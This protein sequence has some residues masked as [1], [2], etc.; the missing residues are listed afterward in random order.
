[1]RQG[2]EQ[3]MPLLTI[4]IS[5][6]TAPIEVRERVALSSSEHLNK[7][8]SLRTLE[9]VDEALMLATC[10]RLEIYCYGPGPDLEAVL[11]WVHES[12]GLESDRLDEYFYWHQDTEAIRHLMRVAGGMDSLVLGESQ[13]LGQL[14]LAWDTARS[15]ETAG[16]IIDRLCQHA[17]TAAKSIRHHGAVGDEP[18]SVAYTAIVLA[19]RLFSDLSARRVLLVGAGEMIELC[20]RHLNQHGVKHLAIAN[21]DAERAQR[22]A[23]ELGAKAIALSELSEALPRADILITSTAS[24]RPI[25]KLDVVRE[26][27]I[28]RRR[29]PM[30]I[31][32]IAVP[33]D[34]EP[35]VG[36]LD[37]VYLYTIDDLQ[38]VVDENLDR[39][40]TAV[41]E[42]E[43]DIEA[44]VEDFIRWMN[45]SRASDSLK[46][47]RESAHGHSRELVERALRK[48]EAGQEP[49]AVLEQLSSTLTN[50]ILHAPSKHLRQA[51]ERNDLEMITSINRIYAPGDDEEYALQDDE[52]DQSGEDQAGEKGHI[53]DSAGGST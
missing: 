38:Q 7:L 15:A 22:L 50:R 4:G 14:K 47:L 28:A 5:H 34:V 33:R 21:R 27:M 46:L 13:I 18:I 43:P 42:A 10:N 44:A 6:R 40:S 41:R 37:D 11:D 31:V 52:E 19:R 39:R 1:M 9:G 12:W 8:T 53:R 45:G 30:F 36:E 23:Q 26:A 25:V 20:A 49:R 2:T 29:Q 48:L 51:A 35:A 32:D 24:T 16:T 3:A 17:V